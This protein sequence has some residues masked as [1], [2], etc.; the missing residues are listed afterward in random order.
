MCSHLGQKMC[1]DLRKRWWSCQE[2]NPLLYQAICLLTW[3]FVPSRS[4]S[5][6]LVT[7]VLF[8]ALDGVKGDHPQV[9]AARVTCLAVAMHPIGDFPGLDTKLSDYRSTL[10]L[11]DADVG[12][13]GLSRQVVR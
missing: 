1:S 5:V 11:S 4:G 9:R 8:S 13:C 7:W 10:C 3:L 2:S 6:P 12:V